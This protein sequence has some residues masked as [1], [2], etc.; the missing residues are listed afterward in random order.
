MVMSLGYSQT[1]LNETKIL[2]LIFSMMYVKMFL[3][4]QW[5]STIDT[6][7]NRKNMLWLH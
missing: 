7:L 2:L 3:R 4:L 1:F 6:D 5:S